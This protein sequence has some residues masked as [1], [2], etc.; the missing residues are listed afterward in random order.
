MKSYQSYKITSKRTNKSSKKI[1]I[2]M[3]LCFLFSLT[4]F[5]VS[6]ANSPPLIMKGSTAFPIN[7]DYIV[8]E[9]ETIN[10]QY[11]EERHSV[12]VVFY[13]H[14]TGPETDLQIGFPNVAN[15]GKSLYDFKAF[16]YPARAEY[17]V[18]EKP[19]G[20][21]PGLDQYMYERI[22]SWTMHF[23]EGERKA[24]LVTYSFYNTTMS[25]NDG[26]SASYILKTGALWKGK[27]GSIDI[28]VDFPEKVAYH[29]IAAS[30]SGYYYNGSGIEWHFEN[31]EPDFD[32]DIFYHKLADNLKL[33]WM[34]EPKHNRSSSDYM[35][36]DSIFVVDLFERWILDEALFFSDYKSEA[37]VRNEA[38]N[39]LENC[40]LIKNEILARHG[41]ELSGEWDDFFRQFPWYAPQE[42]FTEDNIKAA[43]NETET[44]NLELIRDYE[45]HIFPDADKKGIISGLQALYDKYG[46]AFFRY[47]SVVN[48]QENRETI[49]SFIN[50]RI[51]GW[52]EYAPLHLGQASPGVAKSPVILNKVT[53]VDPAKTYYSGQTENGFS[54]I[55]TADDRLLLEK[56]NAFYDIYKYTVPTIMYERRN[57]I[58]CNSAFLMSLEFYDWEMAH[59]IEKWCKEVKDLET[60]IT[61][62]LTDSL[63]VLPEDGEKY[64]LTGF[65]I[66]DQN[67]AWSDNFKYL[68]YTLEIDETPYLHVFN[69]EN[70][71][72][73][74]YPL[75]EDYEYQEIII[76]NDGS[77]FLKF[78]DSFFSFS[79]DNDSI[80]SVGLAGQFIGFDYDRKSLIYINKNEI[81][82]Y[83]DE[84]DDSFVIS[85]PKEIW[86]IEKQ[87]QN[88]Y[89]FHCHPEYYYIFNL[90][91]QTIYRYPQFPAYY[92][93]IYPPYSPSGLY[94]LEINH[95]R[96]PILTKGNTD[97]QTN[98][99]DELANY[100]YEQK[101]LN[102]PPSIYYKWF[103]D[104]ELTVTEY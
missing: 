81:R 71:Y 12:E 3:L 44:L 101:E 94:R 43:L 36:N 33:D 47:Y 80:V 85:L 51:K 63:L 93:F 75:P 98:N 102:I 8:L 32:L 92:E 58:P 64:I 72:L 88:N 5:S 35:W 17:I 97:K 53:D 62:S 95:G 86:K 56:D 90:P 28:S 16:Q 52:E 21:M 60:G 27:I 79:P 19:G 89:L 40:L 87:D 68:A 91:S 34:Y 96:K 24:L 55:T 7:S 31:I 77:G 100:T 99:I 74:R 37:E 84:Q 25:E 14:N 73:M 9:K 29:E 11:G 4:G 78:N 82:Q 104:S 103:T 18:E 67:N 76:S 23:E 61:M 2:A 41:V 50:Q 70:R 57:E 65:E 48:R 46:D 54:I 1:I 15:Y 13:F 6:H 66:Y 69:I 38:K 59:I 49:Q 22:Y 26:G 10:I 20:Q 39:L 30:P 42:G 45:E 83:S